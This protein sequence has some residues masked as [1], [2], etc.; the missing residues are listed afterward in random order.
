METLRSCAFRSF[1][2]RHQHDDVATIQQDPFQLVNT[3]SFR[4]GLVLSNIVQHHVD[5]VIKSEQSPND[6]FVGAKDGV[7]ARANA[8]VDQLQ[9]QQCRWIGSAAGDVG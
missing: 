2:A 6:F 5:V 4:G 9:R 8:L 1:S 3:T 7:D